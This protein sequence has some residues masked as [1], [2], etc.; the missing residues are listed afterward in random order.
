[1]LIPATTDN[2]PDWVIQDIQ[3]PVRNLQGEIVGHITGA[4]LMDGNIRVR[5]V[6]VSASAMDETDT[7]VIC[8]NVTQ[9]TLL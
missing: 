9:P 4:Y 8:S 1:M 7:I 3:G 5:V 2:V 6:P